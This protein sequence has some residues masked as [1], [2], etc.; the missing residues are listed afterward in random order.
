[1]ELLNN[2]DKYKLEI[3]LYSL[4]INTDINYIFIYIYKYL[5][6]IT[7]IN[8]I[9]EKIDY[10]INNNNIKINKDIN[11]YDKL[12]I[13]IF[14]QTMNFYNINYN[15]DKFIDYILLLNIYD[16]INNKKNKNSCCNIA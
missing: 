12:I 11:Y 7:Y 13:I 16:N 14:N 2:K 5:K 6:N 9:Y 3:K 10:L 1:M 4:N 15:L 8:K